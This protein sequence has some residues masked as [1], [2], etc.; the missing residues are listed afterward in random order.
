MVEALAQAR[1][2]LLLTNR[3]LA[4]AYT[5]LKSAQ[6]QLLQQDKMASIGQLAAG[7]AHEINNPMGFILSNLGTLARYCERLVRF[8]DLQAEAIGTVGPDE[9]G[10]D[11]RKRV[12]VERASLKIDTIIN[13]IGD[14][15]AE[16]VE[17]GGRVKQIVMNLKRFSHIDEASVQPTDLNAALDDTLAIV[18]N[19]LKYKV[20][21][22]KDYGELPLLACNV[23]Q[24]NQVFMNLL[25][26]AAQAVSGHGEIRITTRCKGDAVEITIADTGCGMPPEVVPRIFEPFYTTKEVGKGTGLGLS[27]AYDIIQ[28]HHGHI[29]AAS[30]AGQ[31]TTFTITLPI[32]AETKK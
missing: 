15:I 7:V 16:S 32:S 4:T 27:I 30:Q 21:I 19:E 24:L 22:H 5:D 29:V 1:Q 8:I 18:W 6:S 28:K 3:Q 12:A 25:L 10:N 17:G 11:A 31:G 23:G 13:D 20:E 9:G 2:E 26:N 14:L